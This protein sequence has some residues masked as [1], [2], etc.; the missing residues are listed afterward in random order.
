MQSQWKMLWSF[1]EKLKIEYYLAVP[2]LCTYPKTTKT[3]TQKDICIPMFIAALFT[4]AKLWKQ[5]KCT[6]TYKQIKYYVYV[7]DTHTMKYYSDMK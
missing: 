4:V 6:L 3:Q 5:S 2:L 1:F 7:T